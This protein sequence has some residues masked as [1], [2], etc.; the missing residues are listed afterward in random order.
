M[1]KML[2][3]NFQCGVLLSSLA[4]TL[5]SMSACTDY[6]D[7]YDSQYKATYGDDATIDS[8]TPV[9]SNECDNILWLAYDGKDYMEETTLGTKW[10]YFRES[11]S[12]IEF[13]GLDE[14]NIR[15]N[16]NFLMDYLTPYL[17]LD[18]GISGKL[19]IDN[20]AKDF[21]AGLRFGLGDLDL[22]DGNKVEGV[23]LTFKTS[24][25]ETTMS[26][27]DVDENGNVKSE[28]RTD[29]IGETSTKT[30]TGVKTVKLP[31]ESFKHKSGEKKFGEFL[32]QANYLGVLFTATKSND[33]GFLIV[34]VGTYGSGVVEESSDSDDEPIES[35]DS[36]I[37]PK[38]SESGT[39]TK[40]SSTS[41]AKS[42]AS[43]AK[44]SA[45]T[46][47]SSASKTKSS[48]SKTTS[49]SSADQFY[50][51]GDSGNPHIQ[52][53]FEDANSGWW[54]SFTDADANGTSYFQWPDKAG[55]DAR[56]LGSDVEA[57]N[58]MNSCKGICGASHLRF[59][60]DPPL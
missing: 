56:V 28:Y 46:A 27:M 23:C 29:P 60:I 7:E 17:K 39:V 2:K 21:Y 50:W 12:D 55:K 24:Y 45:S 54:F 59:G 51:R 41:T 53:T 5:A 25:Y 37:E 8:K 1:K 34:G 43:T 33:E 9:Y 57:I 19:K 52:T 20:G 18:G 35:S 4:L 40:K 26:L 16:V 44:S 14:N 42:S 11:P 49:S 6:V 48:A 30:K 47:K 10:E 13:T 22:S 3:K 58:V 36:K 15:F 31:L 32:K 38:S